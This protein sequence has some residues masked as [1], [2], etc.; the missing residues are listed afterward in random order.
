MT[1]KMLLV[2]LIWIVAIVGIV[3]DTFTF[4]DTKVFNRK[5]R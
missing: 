2:G 3:H 1:L 5:D 4:L